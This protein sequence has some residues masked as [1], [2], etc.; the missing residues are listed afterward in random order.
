M[1]KIYRRE[2]YDLSQ[3]DEIRPRIFKYILFFDAENYPKSRT[4]T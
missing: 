2:V 4:K 3:L 1:S